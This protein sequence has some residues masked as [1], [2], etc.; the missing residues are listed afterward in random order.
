MSEYHLK[1]AVRRRWEF[2]EFCLSW[3]GSI[4]RKRLQ[5]AFGI[6]LQQA[7]N[8]LNG[9]ADL[10]PHNMTYDPRQKTYVPSESFSPHLID[11]DPYEYLHH[12]ESSIE[13]RSREEA[14]LGYSY[15]AAGVRMVQRQLSGDVLR[16]ILR[17]I[18]EQRV[19]SARYIALDASSPAQKK[20]IVP[21]AL[22]FDGYRWHTRAYN[23][24]KDRFSDYVLSRFK[25]A[26]LKE[27]IS[28]SIRPDPAWTET[29]DVHLMPNPRLDTDKQKGLEFEYQMKKGKLVLKV[30]KAMLFYYLRQYGF[31]P[32]PV[33]DGK[34]RNE[35]SFNLVVGNFDEVERH[36]ARR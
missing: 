32:L 23:I 19:V 4:G 5:D 31:N 36:L 7:T 9:Y 12:I 16:A 18:R 34:M 22:A 17:G 15:K 24:E 8:D 11:D 30:K 29:V 2:I 28:D 13:G 20:R 26:E 10:A 33:D 35:S 25:R 1:E 27:E 21:H 14:W 3:E 6:S